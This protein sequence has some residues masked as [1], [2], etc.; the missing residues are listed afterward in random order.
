MV[1][2]YLAGFEPAIEAARKADLVLLFLGETRDMTGEA[3]SRSSLDLPGAQ[4]DLVTELAKLG[5]PASQPTGNSPAS[6]IAISPAA[7]GYSFS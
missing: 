1:T 6:I 3:S 4:S 2:G 5:K 7:C